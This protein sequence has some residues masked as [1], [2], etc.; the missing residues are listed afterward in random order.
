MQQELLVFYHVTHSCGHQAWWDDSVLADR[1]AV[2]PCPWCGGETGESHPPLGALRAPQGFTILP[3]L[4]LP[5]EYGL[6]GGR[7]T[8]IHRLDETCCLGTVLAK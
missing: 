5:T 7:V 8:V 1:T 4:E 2:A 3:T 6:S